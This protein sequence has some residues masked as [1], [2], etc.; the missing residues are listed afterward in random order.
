MGEVRVMQ[1][2]SEDSRRRHFRFVLTF[3]L[4]SFASVVVIGFWT[5]WS[6]L[7][8]IPILILLVLAIFG[9]V[10]GKACDLLFRIQTLYY[11]DRL[12]REYSRMSPANRE[13]LLS[14]MDPDFREHFLNR[15]KKP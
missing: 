2:L 11:Q 15:I 8:W 3:R 9:F 7:A 5:H 6:G 14:Q 10:A 13:L 1:P 4:L 12:A